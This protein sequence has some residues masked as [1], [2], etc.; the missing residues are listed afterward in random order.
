[1]TDS[2]SACG[3][4]WCGQGDMDMKELLESAMW[5]MES[6][7][8]GAA[9]CLLFIRWSQAVLLAKGLEISSC[10]RQASFFF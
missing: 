6:V 9:L 1:M 10:L 3:V 4:V 2:S 5:N 8:K 7:R